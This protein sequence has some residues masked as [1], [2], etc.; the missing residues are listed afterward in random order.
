MVDWDGLENRSRCKPTVGSNPTPSACRA[1][2]RDR[3]RR[4]NR[5]DFAGPMGRS[6]MH[7]GTGATLQ[8]REITA[9]RHRV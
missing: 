5:A 9:A 2:V 3:R 4:K 8:S 1:I 6:A 7:P